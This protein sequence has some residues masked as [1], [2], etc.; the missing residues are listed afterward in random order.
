MPSSPDRASSR[1][2]VP[3][4]CCSTPSLD[5]EM[6]CS[7]NYSVMVIIWSFLTV[8]IYFISLPGGLCQVVVRFQVITARITLYHTPLYYP[9][10]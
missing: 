1:C 4:C 2:L 5:A 10:A 8:T 6:L 3:L 9:S 7:C